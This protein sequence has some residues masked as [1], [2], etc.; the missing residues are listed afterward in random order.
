MNQSFAVWVVIGFAL[1]TA[2]LPFVMQRPFLVLPWAQ[3]GEAELAS[4]SRGLLSLL[5]FAVLLAAGWVGYSLISDAILLA[6]DPASLLLFVGRL[7]GAIVLPMLLLAYPGWR[8]RG[9]AI[10][11]TFID[12]MIELFVFY[13][14]VGTMGFAFEASIG[15]PFAQ[16]WE[17]Y[18]ITLSL[19]LVLGY[20]GFVFRYLLRRRKQGRGASTAS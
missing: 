17:F 10:E 13:L 4:W 18:A 5:Y 3:K 19:F 15:N 2:N 20:P 1:I 12:R 14:L 16:T 8:S 6:S 7:L 11:K 9:R